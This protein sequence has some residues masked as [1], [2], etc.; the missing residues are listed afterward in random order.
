M[1]GPDRQTSDALMNQLA[2]QPHAFDFFVALRLM[3]CLHPDRPRLGSSRSPSQD[4]I[5]L[6]QSPELDFAPSTLEKLVTREG[7]PPVLHARHFGL[8]GPNGPLPLCLT[9][10]AADRLHG[11]YGPEGRS[12]SDPTLVAFCNVLHHRMMSF[13]YRAW[14]D[15]RKACDY[16]TAGGQ[17]WPYYFGSLIGIG[18]DSLRDCDAVPDQA[19][20]FY[21]GRLVQPSR[22]AEGLQ[23][24]LQD[25]FGL[26]TEVQTFVGQWLDL[27]QA[28]QCKLGQANGSGS[29]GA[30]VI[31]GSRFWTCQ[32]HFR[33][34]MGPMSYKDYERMLPHGASFKRLAAWVRHYAGE[35]YFWDLQLVLRRDEVPEI[36][37]GVRGALGW[38]TWLKT[39][40]LERDADNLVL[41]GS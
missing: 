37:L 28:Q 9:E 35:Q 19:K 32:L 7:Q 29:L 12:P 27:P 16:G 21:A 15:A 18:M 41:A 24:I 39:G 17:R 34:R 40:P 11:R 13:L 3:E 26:H 22:N 25:F 20:L 33:I 5:R 6:A 23:A 31:I 36:K 10:Y 2:S 38:T 1:A 14:A 4:A 30:S 8:F